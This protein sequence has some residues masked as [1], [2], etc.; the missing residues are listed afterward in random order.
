MWNNHQWSY[1]NPHVMVE[2]SFQYRFNVNVWFG[3]ID[4]DIIGPFI[5]EGHLFYFWEIDFSKLD[6]VTNHSPTL[7]EDVSLKMSQNMVFQ[8]YRTPPDKTL[9]IT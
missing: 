2:S 1:E 3:I 9:E 8:Q 5:F 6:F 7:L 4:E